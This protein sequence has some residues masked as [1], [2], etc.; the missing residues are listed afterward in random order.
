[1]H[2]DH[3]IIGQGICGTFLSWYLQ[4]ANRSYV[5][6]DE[7]NPN[8]ASRVAAG[9]INPV[10]GRRIVKTWM[11]DEVMPFAQNAYEKLGSALSLKAI[12]HKNII[13]FFPTPQMKLAFHHRYEKDRQYLSIPAEQTKWKN[14]FNDDFG[15]GE[16][17][18][19]LLVNISGILSAYR[20][21]IVQQLQEE[22][23]NIDLLRYDKDL[24]HYKDIKAGSVIFCDGAAGAGNPFFK[25]LPFAVNKGEVLWIECN[26][27]PLSNIFK[28]GI[29]LVPWKENIFWV[30]SSYEW[31]FQ[32]DLPTELFK[33]KTIAHLKRLLKVPFKVID[34]K[35][36]IRPATLERRPFIGFHPVYKNIGIF[37]GMGTKGCSLSPFFAEQF[38]QHIAHGLP[39]QADVDISRFRNILTKTSQYIP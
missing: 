34:H 39:L 32:N 37:N 22:K 23:F 3:L 29:N 17:A 12:E 10:T 27:L 25:L 4:K 16:I 30:G 13:D 2:V 35:A 19:C 9:I 31:D 38:A 20:S 5:V 18:P 28:Y 26:E 7:A 6:I 24:I 11:I 36:S 14:Y 21:R 15:F 1:M 8:T 33:E